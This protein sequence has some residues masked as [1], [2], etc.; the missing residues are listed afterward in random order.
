VQQRKDRIRVHVEGKE[1][2]VEGG[3]FRE[4][5]AVVKQINGRRFVGE[6]KV[7][8]LPGTEAAVRSHVE[9]GGYQ[10]T[11]GT[12]VPQGQ[13]P[14]QP[15]A[16]SFGNDRIRVEIEGRQMAVSGGQFQEMLAV[17]KNLPDRRFDGDAKIWQ[18]T[19]DAGVIK[20]MIQAAGFTLEG[21]ED[22][23]VTE[24]PPMEPLDFA[25]PAAPPPYEPPDFFDDASASAPPPP[26]PVPP[27]P[28]SDWFEEAPADSEPFP[29]DPIPFEAEL[30]PLS[31][32][33]AS[34]PRP[35]APVS[36]GDRIRIQVGDQM[37]AVTG[38]A[39]RDMLAVVKQIPDRRFDGDS[40]IWQI[41]AE[42]ELDQIRQMLQASGF[43]LSSDE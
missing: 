4:M 30:P 15:A 13:T 3:Q 20:G 2:N 22:I 5:L 11:G 10:L 29:D 37:M 28:P 23:P 21:A 18:I 1:F 33:P 39:F 8:Q 9:N 12:P 41:P 26:P 38:G 25:Q 36:G 35:A 6:L 7:W 32:P 19:G 16:A 43:A 34:P 42:V 40:K 24:V 14:R 31:S 17:V 27:P